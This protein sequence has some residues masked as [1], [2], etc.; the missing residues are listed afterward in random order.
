[1]GNK[2][3]LKANTLIDGDIGTIQFA[4]YCD[5]LKSDCDI[6]DQI[7]PNFYPATFQD[8]SKL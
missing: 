2:T 7:V 1:M 5:E 3:C 8:E 6:N 4:I